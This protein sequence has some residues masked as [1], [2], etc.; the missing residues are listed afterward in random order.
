[1]RHALVVDGGTGAQGPSLRQWLACAVRA[2]L[3]RP[4][5]PQR[6]LGY[7]LNSARCFGIRGIGENH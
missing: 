2:G 3:A 6:G 1:M 5:I 4:P 7:R